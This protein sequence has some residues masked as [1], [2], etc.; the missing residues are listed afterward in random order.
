[1]KKIALFIVL[2]I[3]C[4][5]A[6][7]A[8]DTVELLP[9][10]DF[11]QWAVR[12]IKESRFLGGR[13]K[14]LYAVAPNDTI[15]GNIPF[16]YGLGGNPWSVS[17]AYARVAGIDKASG[18]TTPERRGDG[19]C[20]RLDCKLDSVVVARIIDLKVLVAGTLFTGRTLEPISM[21]AT[22]D[23]YNAIDMGVPFT[24]HPKAMMLDIKAHIEESDE[25]T[26]AKAV[27]NPK[28]RKGRD[29]AEVY[30]LLQH[31][32]ED[33]D[34]KLHAR[35]VATAYERFYHSIPEWD[36]D[37]VIPFRWGD[38]TQQPDF[39]NYERLN[40][41]GFQAMNSKGDMVRVVEEGFGLENPTHMIIMITSGSYEAFVGHNGNT[42]WVDNVR[43]VYDENN[44]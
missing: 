4:T 2:A 6:V 39:R 36:N 23:P 28:I 32:W 8:E 11:E 12:Y 20:A 9:F 18:T 14:T 15:R 22:N 16:T 40:A 34:G 41:I 19:W 1:M 33:A 3:G 37:H 26:Y 7:M 31:R 38:I 25:I 29:C 24:R 42:L 43:F 27:A 13:T 44:R 30:V 5:L 10:G 21:R 17:N 35:R